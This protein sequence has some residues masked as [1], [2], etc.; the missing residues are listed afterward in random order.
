[1][2]PLV[3]LLAFTPLAAQETHDHEQEAKSRGPA[4][5]IVDFYGVRKADRARLSKVLG[6]A[7][8]D[9]LPRAKGDIE[10]RLEAVPGVV[11]ARLEAACCDG[12]RAVLYVGVEEKGAQIFDYRAEPAAEVEFPAEIAVLYKEFLEEVA[13]AVSSGMTAED[14]TLGHSL[15][16][17]PGARAIQEKFVALAEKHQRTLSNVLRNSANEEQR[18]MAAYVIGYAPDKKAVVNDLQYALQDPDDAVRNHALRA[19]TAMAVMAIKRPEAA[20]MVSATWFVEMLHSLIWTDRNNAAVALVTLTETR[21]E[22][23]VAL[24]RERALPELVEMARWQH[25]PHALPGFIL[26]GRV[27]GMKEEDIQEAWKSG[28]RERVISAAL[29]SSARKS[30]PPGRR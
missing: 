6:V 2:A 25:L 21:D 28:E 29:G 11:R 14:L 19:L 7:P 23:V 30:A 18:A 4:V 10:E 17:H 16:D 20:I 13:N 12:N 9:T 5:G 8:G 27:A 22:K 15:L 26:A 3:L 1:V 24:L